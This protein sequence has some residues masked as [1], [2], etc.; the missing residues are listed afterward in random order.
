M[1]V[2][3]ILYVYCIC[4]RNIP[5]YFSRIHFTNELEYIFK[6]ILSYK[7]YNYSCTKVIE[8]LLD[9]TIIYII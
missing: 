1:L 5:T 8:I 2:I 7:L 3:Q 9:D 6:M 4:N